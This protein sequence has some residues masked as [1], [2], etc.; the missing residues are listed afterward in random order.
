MD[1]PRRFPRA[2]WSAGSGLP[3]GSEANTAVPA[4][5]EALRTG[6]PLRRWLLVFDAASPDAVRHPL[7][8]WA[9]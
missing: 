8:W 6:R 5:R 3:G 4:V 9:C 7:A 2:S 1:P